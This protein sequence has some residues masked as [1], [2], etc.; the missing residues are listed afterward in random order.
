MKACLGGWCRIREA[1]PNYNA[2]DRRN[3]A[4]RLCVKGRD[5]VRRPAP[6]SFFV[7]QPTPVFIQRA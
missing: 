6:V 7:P 3:P 5:G 1:C 4:E 2:M